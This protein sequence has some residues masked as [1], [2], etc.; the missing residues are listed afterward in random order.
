VRSIDRRQGLVLLGIAAALGSAMWIAGGV[1]GSLRLPET[2]TATATAS[3]TLAPTPSATS[4]VTATPS[5]TAA[6]TATRKPT[7]TPR[8][9]RPINKIGPEILGGTRLALGRPPVIKLRNVSREY[10]AEVRQLVGPDCLI[11]IRF[12]HDEPNKKGDPRQEARGWFARRRDDMLAMRDAAAPNIAFETAVNEATEEELDWLVQFSLEL[13][14]LM[15]ADGLRCVTGNPAV[16]HWNV[17]NWPK[18]APVLA[19][20]RPDD[21]LGLHE[22]WSDTGDIANRWHCGRWTIPEIAAVLGDVR[23][24]VTECGRDRVEGRGDSGWRRTT[25]AEDFVYD[26]EEYDRLLRESP[27]VVGATVFTLDPNW[28]DFDAS[29]LWPQVVFRYSLTPTPAPAR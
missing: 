17:E 15:H 7:N 6:A 27:N 21:F 20:M 18:F 8:P 9:P 23:I 14:P 4:T 16:G 5:R 28:P 2:P 12:E 1:L 24:V 26:L 25:S 11:V 22:Y 10:V 29:H 3:T 13:I 19:A